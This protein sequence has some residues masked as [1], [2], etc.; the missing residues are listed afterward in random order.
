MV[1]QK[2]ILYLILV[3]CL[4]AKYTDEKSMYL[5]GTTKVNGKLKLDGK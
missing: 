1:P 5:N 4:K 2:A 3:L